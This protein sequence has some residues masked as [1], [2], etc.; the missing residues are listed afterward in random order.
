MICRRNS[1]SLIEM[2]ISFV[3]FSLLLLCLSWM[4]WGYL[5]YETTIEDKIEQTAVFQANTARLQN[6]LS[7]VHFESPNKHLFYS[8]EGE[9]SL[10]K[11]ESLVFTYDAGV[12]LPPVFSNI[13]IGKLYLSHENKLTLASWPSQEQYKGDDPPMRQEVLFEDVTACSL[14]FSLQEILLQHQQVKE[15]KREFGYHIGLKN[16]THAQ[17]LL[18]YILPS[19]RPRRV[20]DNMN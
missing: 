20:K 12:E 14:S 11:G 16:T 18:K 15:L 8:V 7:N 3:L 19:K 1:F 17:R 5:R 9:S 4:F 6:I 13:N 10:E 2:L